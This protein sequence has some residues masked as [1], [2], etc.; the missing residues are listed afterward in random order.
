M[1][2]HLFEILSEK[3]DRYAPLPIDPIPFSSTFAPST[4]IT[5]SSFPAVA[6]SNSLTFQAENFY[7]KFDST[8]NEIDRNLLF[9]MPFQSRI[10]RAALLWKVFGVRK[11]K[12]WSSENCFLLLYFRNLSLACRRKLLF[13]LLALC[14]K[15]VFFLRHFLTSRCWL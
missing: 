13:Q 10:L 7:A 8:R 6:V 12:V 1:A 5:R 9:L 3:N 2:R 14:Q 15:L 4:F 11:S